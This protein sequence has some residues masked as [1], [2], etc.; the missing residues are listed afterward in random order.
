[1]QISTRELETSIA[2]VDLGS[3]HRPDRWLPRAV[4]L[5]QDRSGRG[6]VPEAIGVVLAKRPPSLAVFHRRA[7]KERAQASGQVLRDLSGTGVVRQP[8]ESEDG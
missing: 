7:I 3:R 8:P 2:R 6:G 1:M 4:P 5:N